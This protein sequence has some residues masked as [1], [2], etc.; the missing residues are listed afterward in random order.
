RGPGEAGRHA[1]ARDLATDAAAG[2]VAG[3]AFM[4]RAQTLVAAP[5]VAAAL[6][7]GSGSWRIALRRGGIVLLAAIATASPFLLRNLRL[8]GSPLHSDIAAFGIWPYSHDLVSISATLARPPSPFGFALHHAPQVL[9]HIGAS[10]LRFAVRTCPRDLL[11]N[12]VWMVALAAGIAL[13]LPRWRS[14]SFVYVQIAMTLTL[15]FATN[16]DARYFASLVPL[17]CALA[18]PGA[19]W[20]AGALGPVPLVGRV[21]GS[22]LLVATLAALVLLQAG[23]GRRDVADQPT[24]ENTAARAV[25]PFLRAHLQPDESVMA[26]TTSYYAYWA[27]RPAVYLVIADAP[28]F[29]EVV[30]RLKVRVAALPTSRLAELAAR[31]RDGRLPAALVLDHADPTADVTLFRVRGAGAGR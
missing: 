23:A 21:R 22:H 3:L 19:M 13:S 15:L 5:A 9:A 16:W 25:A 17:G 4:L 20:I 6:L 29:M 14:W 27:D 12:P 26:L 7:A 31:Y 8:F 30:R 2:V 24:T 11:G 1:R 18:A 28:D 10:A